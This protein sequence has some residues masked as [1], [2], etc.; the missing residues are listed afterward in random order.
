V[1]AAACEQRAATAVAA[2]TAHAAAAAVTTEAVASGR[3]RG[4]RGAKSKCQLA[5]PGQSEPVGNSANEPT[6][7]SG[8]GHSAFEVMKHL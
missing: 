5:V 6:Y 1:G 4:G 8:N 2:V 3:R 7:R